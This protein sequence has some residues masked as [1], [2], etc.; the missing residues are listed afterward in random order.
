MSFLNEVQWDQVSLKNIADMCGHSG[1]A[2]PDNRILR[3]ENVL[4]AE[5]TSYCNQARYKCI[6][7]PKAFNFPTSFLL[8]GF[9]LH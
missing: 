4:N 8:Y 1:P 7:S 2:W 3:Q 5:Y 9:K 6:S